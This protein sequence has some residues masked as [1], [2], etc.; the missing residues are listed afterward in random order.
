[1]ETSIRYA[2]LILFLIAVFAIVWT[3]KD[4]FSIGRGRGAG[5]IIEGASPVPSGADECNGNDMLV[6]LG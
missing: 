6:R 1:M 5:P 2:A 3:L 4:G